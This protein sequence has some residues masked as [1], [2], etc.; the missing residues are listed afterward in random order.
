MTWCRKLQGRLF[1][2]ITGVIKFCFTPEATYTMCGTLLRF[3]T[4][5][6]VISHIQ[7]INNNLFKVDPTFYTKAKSESTY[8]KKIK[9]ALFCSIPLD[10]R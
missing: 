6:F 3:I 2:I 4:I 7:Y 8:H 9:K 5:M 1:F 10:D